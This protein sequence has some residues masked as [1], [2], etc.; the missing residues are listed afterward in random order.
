MEKIY[1]KLVRDNIPEIITK[2]NCYSVTRILIDSE[3]KK[4]FLEKVLDNE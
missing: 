4:I 2:D 3:Y 1:T